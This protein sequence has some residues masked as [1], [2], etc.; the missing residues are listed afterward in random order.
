VATWNSPPLWRETCQPR[1]SYP[2]VDALP[3]VENLGRLTHEY[4]AF[5]AAFVD[6]GAWRTQN[7][8]LIHVAPQG[9]QGE[10]ATDTS[11]QVIL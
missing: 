2:L 7:E 11:P 8:R 3:N 1:A 9:P 10:V 4:G 5:L 6:V